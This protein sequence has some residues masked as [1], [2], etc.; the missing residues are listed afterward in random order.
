VTLDARRW[1]LDVRAA[2]EQI[3]GLGRAMT[4]N[5][6]GPAQIVARTQSGV[7]VLAGRS[8][9]GRSSASLARAAR[10]NRAA[11]AR[12]NASEAALPGCCV[13]AWSCALRFRSRIGLVAGRTKAA[14]LCTACRAQTHSRRVVAAT[15]ASAAAVAHGLHMS[16]APLTC[17]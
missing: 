2:Q 8:V 9:D 13:L 12:C 1:T 15:C 17:G 5:A 10:E 7:R 11:G 3:V 16:A 6:N 4:K 14:T